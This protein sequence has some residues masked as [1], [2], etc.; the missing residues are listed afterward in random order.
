MKTAMLDISKIRHPDYCANISDWEKFR[1]TYHGGREFIEEYVVQFS[2]RENLNDYA[3]R[4]NISYCPAF[5][6]AAVNE[7]KNAIYQRM[8]DV[9]RVGGPKNYQ[10]AIKGEKGGVDFTG[11]TMTGYIGRL[12]LPELLSI[13]KV[14]VYIDKARFGKML[15]INQVKAMNKHPYIYLY[16]AESIISWVYDSEGKLL[17]LMLQDNNYTSDPIFGLPCDNTMTF[18]LLEVVPEGVSVTFFSREGEVTG[19]EMLK[20]KEIP[21]VI[22]EISNSLLVDVADYQIAL[23]N[24]ASSDMWY[25]IKANFP[26]YVEQYNPHSDLSGFQRSAAN[27]LATDAN[28]DPGSEATTGSAADAKVA[29]DIEV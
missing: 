4:L 20:L 16:A 25:S 11:N 8:V 17:K 12:I 18:R 23:A 6:K 24:L 9:I 13:G 15:T 2:T 22:L 10:L 7:I 3:D 28:L 21:F 1:F 27:Q 14:G 26:F 5:A 19:L 29:K